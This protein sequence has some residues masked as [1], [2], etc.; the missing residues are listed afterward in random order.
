MPGSKRKAAIKEKESL[1][2]I[3]C[4]RKRIR[5]ENNENKDHNSMQ[6]TEES[7]NVKRIKRGIKACRK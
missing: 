5:D 1:H 3:M 7:S 6:A 2:D 4:G